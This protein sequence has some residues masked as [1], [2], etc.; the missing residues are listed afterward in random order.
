MLV[1]NYENETIL[2]NSNDSNIIKNVRK[3]K[4]IFSE[5]SN[6]QI[7][8]EFNNNFYLQEFDDEILNFIDINHSNKTITFK[9]L[10]N[11]FKNNLEIPVH[12]E[13]YTLLLQPGL[14]LNFLYNA[15]LTI[16][17]NVETEKNNTDQNIIINS[18]SK[19]SY[20]KF[21][22]KKNKLYNVNFTNFN[23]TKIK[24]ENFLTSPITFYESNVELINISIENINAEDL[25]NI[26]NSNFKIENSNFN[27]STSDL[28][29]IDN[30]IGEI[31][32]SKFINCQNDCLDFS[33]SE[34]KLENI[35]I[36]NSGDKG[37]SVGEN[38]NIN[39]NN[40]LINKSSKLCIAAKDQSNL[41]LKNIKLSDCE[42]GIA[43]FI[44][45]RNLTNQ[46]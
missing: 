22:G 2:I 14:K 11:T 42:Y 40:L 36:E 31:I 34:V 24:N 33:G 12:L 20:I 27:N 13:D 30:S 18:K 45:K 10:E 32:N 35:Y 9:D 7:N 39:I 4:K 21:F 25:L 29:D 28:V 15:S 1:N 46:I 38:S 26:V 41:N 5:K 6:I 23:F 19:S 43:A 3:I 8:K 16:Y 44:K 37:L 17:S